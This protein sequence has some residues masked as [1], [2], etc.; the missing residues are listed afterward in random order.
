M[1]F[2]KDTLRDLTGR[3]A[4]DAARESAGI[5]AAAG[6]QAIGTV[7][8]AAARA[9]GFLS[10][11]EQVGQQGLSQAGF[12]GDPNA[13]FD[14]LQNNPLFQQSLDLRDRNTAAAAAS[15]GRLSAGDTALQFG[16][17]LLLSAQPLLDRQRQDIFGQ[18]NFGSG[19]AGQQAGIEQGLGSNIANL[20]TG[21]G[22]TQAGGIVG[23]AN[24]RQA[25][26]T[27]LLNTAL[28]AGGAFGGFGGGGGLK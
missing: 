10:P 26:T 21:I 15:G 3:T 22:A 18:L 2:I 7:G 6:Q 11:F 4:A 23:A 17:N 25:G 16:N 9:Q 24:A 1:G 27:N 12:L 14:F 8:E 19:I 28:M 5:Q 13:Q 20:Q